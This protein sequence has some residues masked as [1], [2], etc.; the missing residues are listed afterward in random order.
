MYSPFRSYWHVDGYRTP[1][2]PFSYIDQQIMYRPS[3][4]TYT[5]KPLSE[6]EP[7]S[8][9]RNARGFSTYMDLPSDAY[10]TL[11]RR[12]VRYSLEPRFTSPV[13]SSIVPSTRYRSANSTHK[14][15]D[16]FPTR[17]QT[18]KVVR[19]ALL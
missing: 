1:R 13:S 5:P 9:Y 2:I 8:T 17:F 11:E 14:L 18:Y 10:D 19:S 12:K 15:G 16:G 3:T 4:V 7:F 6:F